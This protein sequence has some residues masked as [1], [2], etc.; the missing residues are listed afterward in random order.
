MAWEYSDTLH[1][2]PMVYLAAGDLE[3]A[4]RHA[5]QRSEL[6]FFREADHLA[7][8]WLLTVAAI[9]GDFDEADAL[10]QRFR[11]GWTE[12]GSPTL[13][14]IAFAPA[15]AAMAYGIRGD[16]E[17]RLEWLHIFAEMHRVVKPAR[18]RHTIY[19]PAFEGLVALHRG[20][21]GVALRQVA[22]EPESFKPWHDAAWRPW[23]TAVWAEAA[24][25]AAL[26]DRRTR[27]DRARFVVRENPVAAAVVE[28]AA[29]PST[30]ATT[31]RCSRSPR[32]STPPAAR[33]SGPAPWSS[34]AATYAPEGRELLAALGAAPMA[35]ARLIAAAEVRP[36]RDGPHRPPTRRL[37]GRSSTRESRLRQ[38]ST[39]VRA[40]HRDVEPGTRD[41]PV[42]LP[43]FQNGGIVKGPLDTCVNLGAMTP[44]HRQIRAHSAACECVTA[45]PD[46]GIDAGQRLLSRPQSIWTPSGCPATVAG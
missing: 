3:A 10:A 16:D 26:P 23:Y 41:R 11:R 40:Q 39:E 17:A 27:L 13:G 5:Q 29:G 12:A 36:S 35:G 9:S 38:P 33:T 2:A 7:V 32:P 24:V 4:R 14:G 43:K 44:A 37:S 21:I 46:R 19:S 30:S 1:M 25:L 42:E 20:E 28:R 18:G 6:P 45:R 8:E 34:P 22:G 31:R 15:A